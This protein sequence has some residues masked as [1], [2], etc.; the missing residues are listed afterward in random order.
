MGQGIV[1]KYLKLEK[2]VDGFDKKIV[3]VV[4]QWYD[5][6]IGSEYRSDEPTQTVIVHGKQE[7]D[8]L[9]NALSNY[10]E[11]I[12]N[13]FASEVIAVRFR[14]SQLLSYLGNILRKV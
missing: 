2:E 9:I 1:G 12:F 14:N 5:A 7:L 6:P 10:R 4:I 11:N 3:G 13:Y 8:A